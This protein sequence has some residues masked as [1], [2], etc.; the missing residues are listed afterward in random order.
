MGQTRVFNGKRYKDSGGIHK[1][2]TAA[3]TKAKKLRKNGKRARVET[4]ITKNYKR[5]SRD[6]DKFKITKKKSYVVYVR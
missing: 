4:Q 2:K 5:T 3:Q 6:P 1:T